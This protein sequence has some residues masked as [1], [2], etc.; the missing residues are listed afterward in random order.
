MTS[1]LR[2][3]L[4]V[5]GP[6]LLLGGTATAAD[7]L[8]VGQPA[9]DFSLPDQQGQKRGL[10]EW[11]GK[12]LVLY[13]YPKNDT[14]GCTTEACNFRDDWL[15][16]QELGAEVVGVS[17]DTSASHAAFA[18]KHKLPFPLLAD[19]HGEVAARYGALSDWVVVKLA[20]RQT[21]IIDPQ[22]RIAR[23]YRAVDAD[24]HSVEVVADLRHLQSLPRSV[25]TPA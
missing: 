15:Q 20:K 5:A 8:A 23:V 3:V 13:F 2:R 7:A 25:A 17:V 12:W 4:C 19:A 9:P 1:R 6:A 22:G 21:F 24:R 18:Q 10:S 14:P 11:R 16:L